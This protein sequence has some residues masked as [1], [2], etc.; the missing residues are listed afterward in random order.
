MCLNAPSDLWRIEQTGEPSHAIHRSSALC[1][2]YRWL[3]ETNS[4]HWYFHPGH[5]QTRHPNWPLCFATP[6]WLSVAGRKIGLLCPS[7]SFVA[8][9]IH[10]DLLIKTFCNGVTRLPPSLLTD[11]THFSH[12]H[13][14]MS[15]AGKCNHGLFQSFEQMT[16]AL[17]NLKHVRVNNVKYLP[18]RCHSAQQHRGKQCHRY[19]PKQ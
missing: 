6:Q 13:N 17:Q 5:G 11:K 2:S 19:C 10:P 1:T 8:V 18:I 7:L 12:G 3:L 15:M 4:S 16:K 14:K 9:S